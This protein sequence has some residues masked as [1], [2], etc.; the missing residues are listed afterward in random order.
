M[1]ASNQSLKSGKPVYIASNYGGWYI[2][3]KLTASDTI[4][5]YIGSTGTLLQS[6]S[7]FTTPNS[8]N[9]KNQ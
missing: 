7:L 9:S 6:M 3:E 8:T 5:G 4:N 2:F 1:I